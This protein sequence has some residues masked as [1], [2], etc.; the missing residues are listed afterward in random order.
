MQKTWTRDAFEICRS[1]I[2]NAGSGLFSLVNIAVEDTIGCY[3]G[4]I[5][6][7]EAFNDPNRSAS[8]YVLYLCNNHI[9]IGE[10]PHANYTRYI[11]HS[12]KN[13]NAFLITSTRWKTARFEAIEEIKPGNE[14]FFNYGEDYWEI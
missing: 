5:L 4:K 1:T 2:P 7:N 11:N 6:D 12:S 13:P 9:I 10:G 8:D 3:T 14:I